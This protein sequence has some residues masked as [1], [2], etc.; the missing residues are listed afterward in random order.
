M[1]K[2]IRSVELDGLINN[3]KNNPSIPFVTNSVVV[4]L[5]HLQAFIDSARNV[6]N[7]D[8][9]KIHFVRFQLT[10]NQDHIQEAVP[11]GGLSQ[12]S[13]AFV[14]ANIQSGF[15]EWSADDLIN[16]DGTKTTLLVCEPIGAAS[17]SNDDKTG[18]CPPKCH[19]IG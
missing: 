10:R 8:A 18:L 14:P 16:Q 11:G 7:C 1:R 17:R 3:H 6:P 15:P 4:D 13:L 2:N 5:M 12:V 9:V 19:G